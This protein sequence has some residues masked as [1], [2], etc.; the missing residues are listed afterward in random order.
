M[1]KKQGIIVPKEIGQWVSYSGSMTKRLKKVTS[2]FKID[3]IKVSRRVLTG[4]ESRCLDIPLRQLGFTREVWIY[5]NNEPWM[6]GRS[7]VPY[8]YLNGPLRRIRF[9][10]NKS[11]GE[12]LFKLSNR[13]RSDFEFSRSTGEDMEHEP[14]WVRSSTFTFGKNKLLLKE[15][16]LSAMIK[17]LKTAKEI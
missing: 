2:D 3:V 17:H 10:K 8:I 7:V 4:S 12:L 16:F 15:V 5:C 13:K 1:S 11:L 9:L 14:P 6:I